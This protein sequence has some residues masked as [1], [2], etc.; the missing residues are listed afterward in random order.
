[1]ILEAAQ[2]YPVSV[3][4]PRGVLV[5]EGQ[6]TG[7]L[8]VLKS[9]EL[10]IVRD[11]SHVATVGEV[12]AI[13][14]EMSVLLDQ[15]HTATVRSRLGA[16]VYVIDDPDN[17]L[18]DNRGVAREIASLLATR[19]QKTTALL[20]DMRRQAKERQDQVMFDEIFALLK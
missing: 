3:I 19:L 18:D 4:E 20:V 10:E 2:Y 1:M 6:K 5:H 12:G 16:E 11:G 9:G 7:K 13:I 17:F 15:P 8:Y 14:G